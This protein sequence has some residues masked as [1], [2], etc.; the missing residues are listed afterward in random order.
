MGH[1]QGCA[2]RKVYCNIGVPQERRTIPYKQSKLTMKLEKEQQMRPKVSRRWDIIK[3]R[4]EIN[5][6]EKNK[7]IERINE[8][9][10]WFFKKINKIDKPLAKLIKK[11]RES[12]HINRI[13][14]EKGK[15]T[16]DTIEI[17]RIIRD[18][19]EKLYANNN[20]EEMDNFP[21][22]Y[23]LPRLTQKET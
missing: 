23:N 17:Q 19:Y 14:N 1:S 12:I 13:R 10:S 4:A 3:N 21:E 22:K 2:R 18:Y 16:M 7:T 8:S 11:K 5:K 6:I 9:K 20:L 15:I